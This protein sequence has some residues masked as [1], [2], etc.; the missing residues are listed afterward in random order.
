MRLFGIINK[1][2]ET[3]KEEVQSHSTFRHF[4][5]MDFPNIITTDG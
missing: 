4:M 2:P 5:E 1:G 3:A